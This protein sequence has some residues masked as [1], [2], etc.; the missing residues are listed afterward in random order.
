MEMITTFEQARSPMNLM[1]ALAFVN[2]CAQRRH[3]TPQLA[4]QVKDFL[5]TLQIHPDAEIME[6]LG[7]GGDGPVPAN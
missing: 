7:V 1:K 2:G 4:D 6:W 5:H 3:F